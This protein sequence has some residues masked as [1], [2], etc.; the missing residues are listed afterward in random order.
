[1]PRGNAPI[2]YSCSSNC[3]GCGACAAVCPTGA[4]SLLPDE[5]GF[6]YPMIDSEKCVVCLRCKEACFFQSTFKQSQGPCYAAVMK[7]DASL[8]SSGGAFFELASSI[9]KSGG[10]AFGAAHVFKDS[11]FSVRHIRADTI[12][13]L[14]LIRGSKYVQSE[15]ECCYR[16]VLEQLKTGRQVVFSGTPCQIAGIKG[17]LRKEWTNLF[18]VDLICHGVPSPKMLSEYITKLSE[19]YDSPVKGAQFRSKRDGWDRSLLL[20]IEFEDGRIIYLSPTDSSYYSLFLGLRLFRDSC[21]ACPFAGPSRPGDITLG[22]FWGVDIERPDL[23]NSG[24]FN[25]NKGISC[26]IINSRQGLKLLD[27][28]GKGLHLASVSFEEV[29]KHNDQLRHPS[30]IPSDRE[31]YRRAF[32]AGGWNAVE[33]LWEK[34]ERGLIYKAKRMAKRIIPNAVVKMVRKTSGLS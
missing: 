28:Y 25:L 22:D 30:D 27:K 9:I 17:F 16:D 23:L 26:I 8:S 2:L 1:M 33:L 29:S 12:E 21:Y 31:L 4:I 32:C 20:E 6:I 18:T 34:R 5:L 15:T 11:G 19:E 7:G 24:I 13:D 10:C 3:S 14:E